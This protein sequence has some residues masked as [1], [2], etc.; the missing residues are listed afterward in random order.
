M[1]NLQVIYH[2]LRYLKGS[3]GQVVTFELHWLKNILVDFE[4]PTSF[5]TLFCDNNSTIQLTSNLTFYDRFKHID[6]DYYFLHELVTS[7]FIR[8]IDVQFVLIGR[9]L[10]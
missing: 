4:L 2:L 5:V 7:G 3:P 9:S 8:L 10:N 1:S 6:I